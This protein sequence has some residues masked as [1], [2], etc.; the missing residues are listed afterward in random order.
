MSSPSLTP[1]TRVLLSFSRAYRHL[2]EH[3]A[4]D[5]QRANIQVRFDPW[6]GGGGVPSMPSTATNLDDVTFVIPLL[7]PSEATAS[8]MDDTWKRHIYEPARHRHIDILPVLGDASRPPEFLEQ[9]SYANLFNQSYGLE[10]QRL[11]QTIQRRSGDRTILIPSIDEV[12]DATPSPLTLPSKRI[13]LEVGPGLATLVEDKKGVRDFREQL[14]LMQDG[15]FYELGVTFP[16]PTLHVIPSFTPTLARMRFNDV[17]ESEVEIPRAV[18]MVNAT[19]EALESRGITA[20]PAKNPANGMAAAWIPDDQVAMAQELG[21][22]TWD[23]Y[24]FLIL[25][26][27]ALLRRRAATFIGVDEVQTMLQQIAPIYPQLIAETVPQPVSL[28]LLT[29]VLR[30]LVLE[31]VSI[32]NLP[33][34]LMSL[35]N[36][37]R[38]ESDPLYLTEYVRAGLQRQITHILT[39]GTRQF[40]VFLLDPAIESLVAAA[41]RQ[42]PTGSY[43]DLEPDRLHQILT[44]IQQAMSAIPDHMQIPQILTQMEIRASM[45]RLVALSLPHLPVISYQEMNADCNIQPIGRISLDQGVWWRSGVSFDGVP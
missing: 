3:L 15:L 8:W 25:W 28:F 9:L 36:W 2:A 44:A 27:A 5:L 37:G 40:V 21:L 20:A 29:E 1:P 10:L 4:T 16:P 26:L 39:R 33:K 34:I 41:I 7:T 24:Q 14:A 11:V 45:R 42:T 19:V 31:G 30:R 12:S 22:T 32:R 18:V 6:E 38:F 35:A 17:P 23:T 43:V 13:R